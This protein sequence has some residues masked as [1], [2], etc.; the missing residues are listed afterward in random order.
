MACTAVTL[1]GDN[2][3]VSGMLTDSAVSEMRDDTL[4]MHMLDSEVNE[5][6]LDDW[7]GPMTGDVVKMLLCCMNEICTDIDEGACCRVG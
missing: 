3:A 1:Q 7:L 6:Q 2:G 4:I 5:M